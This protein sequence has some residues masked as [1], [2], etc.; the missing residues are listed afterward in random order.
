MLKT[1]AVMIFA[2]ASLF[3]TIEV[4]AGVVMNTKGQVDSAVAQLPGGK[5]LIS[6][7][8]ST[9]KT[10]DSTKADKVVLV[11][12]VNDAQG[13]RMWSGEISAD[14]IS[15]TGHSHLSL[16]TNTC[17]YIQKTGCGYI[18]IQWQKNGDKME[19]FSGR[20]TTQT[21][22]IRKM[23][24][25]SSTVYSADVSGDLVGT[26]MN[27]AVG[28]LSSGMFQNLLIEKSD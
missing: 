16:N 1:F 18:S 3:A 6:V 10:A 11:Y 28:N 23:E 5:G 4:N 9:T 17:S 14:D 8:I 27:A 13:F 12:F 22:E 7:S 21:R 15:G 2:S 24:N 19:S 20:R 25:G 26:S